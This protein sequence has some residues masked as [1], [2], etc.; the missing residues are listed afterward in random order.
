MKRYNKWIGMALLAMP[1]LTACHESDAEAD[2]GKT[3]VINSAVMCDADGKTITKAYLGEK[4][5]FLGSNMGDVREIYF[6][7]QAALLNPAYIT[8]NS[9]IVEVPKGISENVTDEVTFVTSDG[10]KAVYPFETLVPVPLVSGADCEWVAPGGEMT[11]TGDYFVE[12]QNTPLKIVFAGGNVEVPRDNIKKIDRYGVT[13]TVPEGVSEGFI[14]VTSPYGLGC[15]QFVYQDTR[16]MMFD[17]DGKHGKAMAQSD[18]W[19]KGDGLIKDNDMEIPALDGNYLLFDQVHANM[20]DANEDLCSI[21]HFGIDSG[22]HPYDYFPAKDWT[23][24][25]VKFEVFI[26]ETTPY[27]LCPLNIIFTPEISEG[28]NSFIWDDNFPR[29]MWV[30]FDK[31]F[32]KGYTTGGKWVTVKIPLEDFKYTRYMKTCATPMDADS[33][34][35]LTLINIGGYT[36]DEYKQKLLNMQTKMAIDNFRFV[37]VNETIPEEYQPKEED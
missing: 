22:V 36:S 12:D 28:T 6:N 19:R 27:L 23:K 32:K 18:G 25:A 29:A 34:G 5:A 35:T 37:P 14:T 15:S 2:K 24:W 13:F 8:S 26:P 30:P 31:D 4:I 9:I 11:L 16:H 7:D 10:H 33:F 1:M 3:P 21:N 20:D 17:F